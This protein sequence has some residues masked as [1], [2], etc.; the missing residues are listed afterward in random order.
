MAKVEIIHIGEINI[1]M[2]VTPVYAQRV[3]HIDRTLRG[4]T[5]PKFSKQ[6]LTKLETCHPELQHLF[7]LVI[8]KIDCRVLEGYRDKECQEQY[9]AEG[10]SKVQWPN[11]KHN[12]QPSQAVDIVPYP[13]EWSNIKRWYYFG[14]IVL[15]IAH[16]IDVS[17]RWGGD[18]DGD[19]SFTDQTFHDLPHFELKATNAGK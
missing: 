7:N 12:Q 15:G 19:S 3:I 4:M 8:R 5:M 13:I 9:F 16:A 11:G 14:G 17:I 2:V 10:K 1:P 6:S 18:W